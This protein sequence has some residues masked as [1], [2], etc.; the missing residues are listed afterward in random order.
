[1]I[2]S[3]ALLIALHRIKCGSWGD[4]SYELEKASSFS[5][6]PKIIYASGHKSYI[7]SHERKPKR[8]N[9][10]TAAVPT[11]YYEMLEWAY[12]INFR[13]ESKKQEEEERGQRKYESVIW[14]ARNTWRTKTE[15]MR[16]GKAAACWPTVGFWGSGARLAIFSPICQWPLGKQ[17][18]RGEWDHRGCWKERGTLT[19]SY[20]SPEK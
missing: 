14:S 15:K 17:S 3:W 12:F 6:K 20:I 2:N 5:V 11:C 10:M 7:I 1:M 16:D 13:S 9:S 8:F 4:A 19:P 18:T